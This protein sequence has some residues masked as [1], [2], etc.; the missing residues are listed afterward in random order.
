M[1][2]MCKNKIKPLCKGGDWVCSAPAGKG[3]RCCS[4]G[5]V[6]G[7][8]KATMRWRWTSTLRVRMTPIMRWWWTS[9]LRVRMT[10]NF[11]F[12]VWLSWE[13]TTALCKICDQT[14]L[15]LLSCLCSQQLFPFLTQDSEN[16]LCLF[17]PAVPLP[18]RENSLFPPP[19]PLPD[20]GHR[21]QLK[22]VPNNCSPSWHKKQFKSVPNTCSPSWHGT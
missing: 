17:L 19:V 5:G 1:T 7:C 9:T 20:A 6:K 16:S 11:L 2:F 13:W 14:G 3:G 22:S 18:D 12:Y 10:P 21:K 4:K 8:R 15:V